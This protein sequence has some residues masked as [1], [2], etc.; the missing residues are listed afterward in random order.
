MPFIFSLERWWSVLSLT[1]CS[2]SQ[3]LAGPIRPPIFVRFREDCQRVVNEMETGIM[4]DADHRVVT[5]VGVGQ[6]GLGKPRRRK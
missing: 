2:E 1:V 5:L 6:R 3:N 4:V